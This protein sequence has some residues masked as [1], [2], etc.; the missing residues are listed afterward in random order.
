METIATG[1]SN[2]S[3]KEKN[4][5]NFVPPTASGFGDTFRIIFRFEFFLKKK[6]RF[7]DFF[8][9]VC[10]FL[11]L[12]VSKFDMKCGFCCQVE[13]KCLS[14][15]MEGIS[16]L[17]GYLYN[18]KCTVLLRVRRRNKKVFRPYRLIPNFEFS[19]DYHCIL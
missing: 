19:I 12:Y 11:V 4:V 5:T 3:A 7:S 8:S 13:R 16:G 17:Y 15:I 10:N 6:T 14:F 9:Y 1:I 18:Y 2:R